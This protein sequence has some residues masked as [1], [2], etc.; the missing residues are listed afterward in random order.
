MT[1]PAKRIALV[2]LSPWKHGE[3]FLSF[4][5]ACRRLHAALLSDPRL[6]GS[7][8]EVFESGAIP[9]TEWVDRLVA[10]EPDMLA[11]STYLWSLPSFALLAEQVKRRLPECLT[12]FGGPSARPVVLDLAPYRSTR[13]YIDVL[14]LGEGERLVVELAVRGKQPTANYMDLPGLALPS[15]L[16][17]RQ[18]PKPSASLD[19]NS[20]ASPYVMGL[21]PSGGTAYLETFRGCPMSCKFCQWGKMDAAQ[22]VTSVER[23]EAELNAIA[24]LDPVGVA[25]VDAG[26]NLNMRA[27]RN[28]VEAEARTG[29]LAGR[30]LDVGLYPSMLTDEHIEF[31]RHCRSRVGVGLQTSNPEALVAQ[32]RRYSEQLF[33]KAVERLSAVSDVT[34]EAIL[35]LPGDTL[36][37]FKETMRRISDLPCGIRVYQCL[38]LPDAL[39]TDHVGDD[40]VRFHPVT[41]Q[42]REAPGWSPRDLEEACDWL[43]QWSGATESLTR[44]TMYEHGENLEPY[45]EEIIQLPAWVRHVGRYE[46][47]LPQKPNEDRR[48]GR[49]Y[50]PSVSTSAEAPVSPL[51][52]DEL[53]EAQRVASELLM[54]RTRG[55]CTVE[56]VSWNQGAVQSVFRLGK[57][58]VDVVARPRVRDSDAFVVIG[59]CEF[60]YQVVADEARTQAEGELLAV[61][62]REVWRPL[63]RLVA[64]ADQRI[65]R[66]SAS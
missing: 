63:A 55:R 49:N 42:V 27:F 44:T 20:L 22:G 16:G 43:N 35:G 25:V 28:L 29:A 48:Q 15:P 23:L 36:E 3:L 2:A 17:W 64:D 18:T 6:S 41:L 60:T 65:G 4:N 47:L 5:L 30:Y 11:A 32:G 10:F 46:E 66:A 9:L 52:D 57:R 40:Q 53:G 51:S 39:L 7:Q 58:R 37:G 54:R 33:D 61:C 62:V 59:G 31:V 13:K 14:V 34:V 21:V 1:G 38:I 56:A 24:E 19:L 8:V 50:V 12:V 45:V 26:L